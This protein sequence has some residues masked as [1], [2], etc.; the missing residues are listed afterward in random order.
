MPDHRRR[1]HDVQYRLHASSMQQLGRRL[2]C[3]RLR[4]CV[5]LGYHFH[6]AF[7]DRGI[8]RFR[9]GHR[10]AQHCVEK[11]NEA[12]GR[13]VVNWMQAM[14]YSEH[15]QERRES[16]TCKL[17][18]VVRLDALRD[19]L[20]TPQPSEGFH[21]SSGRY[22]LHQFN[23]LRVVIDDH[24]SASMLEF[25]RSIWSADVDRKSLPRPLEPGSRLDR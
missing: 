4:W 10:S 3:R 24:D 16:S 15:C 22:L 23:P 21:D 7:L 17:G 9:R 12:R 11:L 18:S 19:A 25:G 2:S 5:V 13:R 14:Y 20:P 8:L 6:D 1:S